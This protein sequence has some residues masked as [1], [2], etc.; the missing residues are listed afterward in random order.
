[1]P[2]YGPPRVLLV[3]AFFPAHG[4]GIEVVAG[5]LATH[6]G[7][8]GI[9]MHW[10]AGGPREEH[11]ATWP[12]ATVDAA[13][14]WDPLERRLGL[15]FP[16]WGPA[17][18]ARLWRRVGEH[19]VVHVHDFLYLPT[20]AAMLFAALRGRP[21][22]LTQHIG[23]IPYRS[24]VAHAVLTGLNRSLGGLVLRR[25][26][27]AVF[28]GLPVQRYFETFVRFKR[29]PLLIPNGVD[30]TR[31][32]PPESPPQGE[33]RLL[34]VGRFVEKKGLLLLRHCL[35]LPGA[36][37]TL[38][39][40]GP[41]AM[42][43][44]PQVQVT[45]RLGPSEVARHMREADLLVLPSTGEGFP[46]VVQEALASGTPVLVST[47]VFEAFPSI[48][49]RCVFHVEVRGDAPRQA[50]R[51]RLCALLADPGRLREARGAAAALA[52]QWDWTVTAQRYAV[53][54]RGLAH[55]APH[56]LPSQ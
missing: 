53:L 5:A 10:M 11:P 46:L 16:L 9:A 47:E 15:P 39:G 36:T 31:F 35:D 19:D 3:S 52:R 50:L 22:V 38:V 41:L 24:R 26:T 7:A 14:S 32:Y 27:Q 56:A 34:F 51:D 21:V 30:H 4:G 13:P 45:G 12:G 6:L 20:L 40:D 29:P 17:G 1:M 8:A 33:L 23:D 54:Y 48:D 55:T 49:D 37:W 28:V 2:E 18:L 42:P 44:S 25:V 43:V